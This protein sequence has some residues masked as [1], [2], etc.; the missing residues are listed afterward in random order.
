MGLASSK[1]LTEYEERSFRAYPSA[2]TAQAGFS[3]LILPQRSATKDI[4]RHSDIG[5]KTSNA[6][7]QRQCVWEFCRESCPALGE[8]LGQVVVGSWPLSVDENHGRGMDE[9]C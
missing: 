6:N 4:M 1:G 8:K 2:Y 3:V 7:A 9:T 5:E